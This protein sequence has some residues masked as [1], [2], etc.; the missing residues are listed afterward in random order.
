MRLA[1]LSLKALSFR[2]GRLSELS[3]GTLRCL[4]CLFGLPNCRDMVPDGFS[5]RPLA[6]SSGH[7]RLMLKLRK[8]SP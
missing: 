3:L 6:L 7:A 1:S 2:I 5:L 8:K 4:L